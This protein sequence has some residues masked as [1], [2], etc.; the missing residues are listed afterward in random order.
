M[1]APPFLPPAQGA[2]LESLAAVQD[3]VAR[4]R[5]SYGRQKREQ[6]RDQLWPE[7]ATALW[8]RTSNQ[9]FTTVPRLMS[10]ILVLIRDLSGRNDPSR[11]YLD[12]WMRAFDDA[13][14][15]VIQE[16]Q[17]A[18]SAGYKGNRAVR[19]WRERVKE[20][21]QLGFVDIKSRGNTEVAYILLLNPLHTVA[22]LRDEGR[23]S[24][25]WWNAYVERANDIGAELPK[26]AVKPK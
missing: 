21:K 26:I 6:L 13:F 20:L 4:R 17:F 14:I 9:G 24:D 11:V 3:V 12:L 25:D 22:R 2:D 5:R 10:L 7:S 19:S 23:I 1:D 18:Y 8:D 15:N 16:D